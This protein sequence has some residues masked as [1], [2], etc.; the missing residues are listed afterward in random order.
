MDAD[1]TTGIAAE[2]LPVSVHPPRKSQRYDFCQGLPYQG[3]F[4]QEKGR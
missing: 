3:A 2:T 1:P 4:W